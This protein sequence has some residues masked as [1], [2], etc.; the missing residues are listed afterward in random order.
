MV[1]MNL[2]VT[3]KPRTWERSWFENGG[4]CGG[5]VDTFQE[6]CWLFS[7]CW[8]DNGSGHVDTLQAKMLVFVSYYPVGYSLPNYHI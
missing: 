1:M 7:T 4:S 8:F 6:I 2:L 3:W 5:I